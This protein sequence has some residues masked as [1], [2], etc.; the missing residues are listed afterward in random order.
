MPYNRL[1]WPIVND[2]FL[3]ALTIQLVLAVA[4]HFVGFLGRNFKTISVVA[5]VFMGFIFGVWSNPTPVLVSGMGGLLVAGGS[6]LVGAT[7]VFFLGNTKAKGLLWMV[8]TAATGGAVAAA[9]GSLVGR[10]VFGP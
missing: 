9:I 2:A 10:S 8:L 7:I 3:T 4:G 5:S 1:P 6:A